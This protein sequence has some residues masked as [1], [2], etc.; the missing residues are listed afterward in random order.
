MADLTDSDILALAK[1]SEITIPAELLAEVGYSLNGLL[2]ALGN[3]DVPGIDEVEP[4]PI[5]LPP[6]S[7]SGS[8]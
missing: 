4:L 3:I 1:A 2:E 8:R 5:V 6:T 7:G